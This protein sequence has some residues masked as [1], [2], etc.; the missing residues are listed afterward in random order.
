MHGWGK[1]LFCAWILCWGCF[2]ETPLRYWRV[3]ISFDET[4]LGL[5]LDKEQLRRTLRERMRQ[6]SA[7]KEEAGGGRASVVAWEI[8]LDEHWENANAVLVMAFKFGRNSE[9]VWRLQKESWFQ[10]PI[11]ALS[12]KEVYTEADVLARELLRDGETLWKASQQ[13][14][15]RLL[16]ELRQPM[17]PM[18][19]AALQV[20]SSR[21]NGDVFPELLKELQSKEIGRVRRAVGFLVELRDERAAPALAELFLRQG[22][23][24]RQEVLYA[25]A[26]VG[27]EN[28]KAFLFTVAQGEDDEH[29]ALQAKAL[30]GELEGAGKKRFPVVVP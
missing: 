1:I 4:V 22:P 15:R 30:L 29:L 10:T 3:D 7:F 2:S 18:R 13:S 14:D 20:L 19:F 23:L 9:T 16:Q 25:V 11:H 12:P 6:A 28:A 5:G 27:G 24:L 26:A 8:L 21:K 17:S